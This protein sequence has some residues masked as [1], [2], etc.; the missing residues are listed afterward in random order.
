VLEDMLPDKWGAVTEY[1]DRK[2]KQTSLKALRSKKVLFEL[3]NGCP[4]LRVG[5]IM[6]GIYEFII[7]GCVFF[8]KCIKQYPHR[9]DNKEFK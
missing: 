7:N 8:D 4:A 3:C 9:V 2:F 1:R 5:Y 6:D